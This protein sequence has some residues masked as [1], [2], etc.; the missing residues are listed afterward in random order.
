MHE[1]FHNQ[2]RNS[3]NAGMACLILKL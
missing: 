2:V 3:N 1:S